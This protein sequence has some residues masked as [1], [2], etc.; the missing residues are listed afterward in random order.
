ME[1]INVQSM[2]EMY[3]ILLD[4][5]P[6][7]DRISLTGHNMAMFIKSVA[8]I[9]TFP[10]AGSLTCPAV[11][12]TSLLLSSPPHDYHDNGKQWGASSVPLLSLLLSDPLDGFCSIF[13]VCVIELYFITIPPGLQ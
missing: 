12:T 5:L 11:P 10:S 8:L 6:A 9:K 7:L 2:T 3:Q 13:P 1:L 4:L